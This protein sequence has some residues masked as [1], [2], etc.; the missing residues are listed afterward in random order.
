MPHSHSGRQTD[1]V[2]PAR[3]QLVELPAEASVIELVSQLA[4][5]GVDL[6]ELELRRARVELQD[7]AARAVS[8][9]V[10]GAIALVFVVPASLALAGGLFLVMSPALG[11][12]AAAFATSGL[13]LAVAVA[14]A[15]AARAIVRARRARPIEAGEG[16]E[17]RASPGGRSS[18]VS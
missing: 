4:R 16:D 8:A 2:G 12:P 15:V 10:A 17:L 9:L 3:G 11:P 1:L 7:R 6:V 13:L 5:E 14:V 18:R